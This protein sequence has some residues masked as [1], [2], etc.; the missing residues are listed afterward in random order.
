[1]LYFIVRRPACFIP[2][3][4]RDELREP[5]ILTS[6]VVKTVFLWPQSGWRSESSRCSGFAERAHSPPPTA[7][8]QATCGTTCGTICSTDPPLT[9]RPAPPSESTRARACVRPALLPPSAVSTRRVRT[10]TKRGAGATL[11]T[12]ST[13]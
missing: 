4:R 9:T 11:R 8:N 2:P 1:M 12:L 5:R 6:E 13:N 7:H 10:L 3:A